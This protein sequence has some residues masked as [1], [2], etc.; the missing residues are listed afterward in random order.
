ML[1]R[2]IAFALQQRVF[3]LVLTGALIAAGWIATT[4]LPIE[5]FPDVQDV[6]VQV[7]TQLPGLAPEEVERGVTLPIE[8]E[9]SGVPRQTQLRSVTISGLSVVTLTF[10]DGTDDYFARQQVLE[11]LQNVNLPAGLQ[12][13]L[14]PLTTAVGEVYRYVLEIPKDMPLSEAR[15]IGR[16]AGVDP[17]L[18]FEVLAR[19]SADSF[20]LRN[21]GMKAIVPGDFPE[22]AFSV[23]YA[24][25]DLR[26]ALALAR[27]SGVEARA[28]ELVDR[29]F[30]RA[31][32]AGDGDRY[33]PVISRLIDGE[34]P[35]AGTA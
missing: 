19:G 35:G 26:Y 5:A 15:A 22:R 6:Q 29:Y 4:N 27:E 32:A 30:E 7:V 28:A 20:A 8:R 25:K 13:Q 23:A 12:P 10:G 9:M 1:D 31:I 24:R 14:A 16:R 33:H 21:H 17:A 18:L 11:K 2:L 3:M 34:N